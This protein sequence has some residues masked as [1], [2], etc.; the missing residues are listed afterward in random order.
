M[1]LFR[2]T[3]YTHFMQFIQIILMWSQRSHAQLKLFAK[4]NSLCITHSKQMKF[5]AAAEQQLQGTL[6]Y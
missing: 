2:N 3:V 5:V 1:N 6:L 4:T